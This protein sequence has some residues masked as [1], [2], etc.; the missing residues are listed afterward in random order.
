MRIVLQNSACVRLHCCICNGWTEK[1]YVTAVAQDDDGT[2]GFVC[3]KCIDAGLEG[4]KKRSL[5]AAEHAVVWAAEYLAWA[6]EFQN[7]AVV[8]PTTQALAV[9]REEYDREVFGVACDVDTSGRLVE[10]N[11]HSEF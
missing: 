11:T 1:Y 9:A 5:D 7:K 8:C 4:M 10:E 3:D 2:E 6:K